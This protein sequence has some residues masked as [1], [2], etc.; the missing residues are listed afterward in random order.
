[1]K[2]QLMAA[3][4]L[5]LYLSGMSSATF[6]GMYL[7]LRRSDVPC[8]TPRTETVRT[9]ILGPQFVASVDAEIGGYGT[10]LCLL[11]NNQVVR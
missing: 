1:M 7:Q 9:T 5:M 8:N 4:L 11:Q 10:G 3:A 6:T 2:G